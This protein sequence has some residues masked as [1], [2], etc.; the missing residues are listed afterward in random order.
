MNLLISRPDKIGD[1]ILALHSAKQFKK[2]YP[3]SK[4]YFYVAEYTKPLVQNIKFIDHCI[5][6]EEEVKGVEFDAFIDL[7]A[8]Y[9][10]SK[11]FKDFNIPLRI[12]NSARWFRFNYNRTFHL[13]RSKAILNEAE[14]NWTLVRLA[15]QEL[16]NTNLYESI[17]REDYK[18]IKDNGLKNQ[19]VLMPSVAVSARGWQKEKWFDL[20]TLFAKEYSEKKIVILL[21]P[22][23]KKLEEYYRNSTKELENINVVFCDKYPDLLAT[24]DGAS[25]FVGLSSGVTHIAST[26]N[27]KGIALYPES[28]SMHPSRWLPFHSS[29]KALSLD[30]SPTPEIVFNSFQEGVSEKYNPLSRKSISAFVVSFN[31]EENI[32]RCLKSLSWCDETLVVDSFSTDK[33]IEFAKKYTDRIIQRDWIGHKEQKHFALKECKNE[34]VLSLDADEEV[35]MELKGKIL[36]IL[37]QKKDSKIKGYNINRLVSHLGIWWDKG[38]WHPE[39]RT[40]LLH[41]DSTHWGGVNP[42]DKAIVQ[43]KKGKIKESIFHYTYTDITHQLD[44]LNKHSTL[45]AQSMYDAGKRAKFFNIIFNPIV[46][47]LKFFILKFGFRHGYKGFLV[48]LIEASYTFYK[49]AKLWEIEDK[50]DRLLT[51]SKNFK[52][53]K[54]LTKLVKKQEAGI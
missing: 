39:Y 8:K 1:V 16:K 3:E 38:G 41:K 17:T 44:C 13:R 31:E 48:A 49:Y 30:R 7:M 10:T 5:S 9:R 37:S 54:T 52:I 33:T 21:G 43:G 20:A 4:I 35:S 25:G 11:L 46:R 32:E 15:K 42:H 29:L 24:L 14:Y 40:R 34:W 28:K 47:F 6:S 18:E 51:L 36:N 26:L 2:F 22:A 50:D 23:E 53:E 19:I 45:A 27:I 12:G